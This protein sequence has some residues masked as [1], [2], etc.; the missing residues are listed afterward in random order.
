[1]TCA[2]VNIKVSIEGDSTRMPYIQSRQDLRYALER[3]AGDAQVDDC[4]MS[5]EIMW[6]PE[7]ADDRLTPDDI[8]NNYPNLLQ[9]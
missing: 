7:H 4:L 9:L 1:M 6:T 3:I 2:M 8:Y 5:A